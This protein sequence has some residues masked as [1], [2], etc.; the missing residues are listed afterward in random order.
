[1]LIR[2]RKAAVTI[3]LLLIFT[4]NRLTMMA[5]FAVVAGIYYFLRGSRLFAGKHLLGHVPPSTIRD[6]P[7][8]LAAVSG[9][10]TGPYTLPGPI[11]GERCYLYQTTVWQQNKSDRLKQWKKVAEET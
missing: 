1:M 2:D 5:C 9:M 7:P 8:G 4:L 3:C 6:A 11:T 10:A